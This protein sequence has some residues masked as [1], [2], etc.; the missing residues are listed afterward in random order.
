[1]DNDIFAYFAGNTIS[2]L[3]DR[4]EKKSSNKE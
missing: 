3:K 4:H 2:V 1:M